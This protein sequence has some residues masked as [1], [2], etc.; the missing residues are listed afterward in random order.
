MARVPR[1]KFGLTD[2]QQ[3]RHDKLVNYVMETGAIL[4]PMSSITLDLDDYLN[5][6]NLKVKIDNSLELIK[7][8]Q[9][10]FDDTNLYDYE[11]NLNE[12]SISTIEAKELD[13]Y[14]IYLKNHAGD[15]SSIFYEIKKHADKIKEKKENEEKLKRFDEKR[16]EIL[17]D[18]LALEKEFESMKFNVRSG[19]IY[20][21]TKDIILEDRHE[22]KHNLGPF[23]ISYKVKDAYLKV[24]AIA[25][26]PNLHQRT[27][28][29]HPHIEKNGKI[30]LGD[31][32]PTLNN[33][34][35]KSDIY[36]IFIILRNVLSNYNVASPYSQLE[37]WNG[38]PCNHCGKSTKEIELKHCSFCNDLICEE[39]YK[40]FETGYS[41][42]KI[43]ST[44]QTET[45]YICSSVGC[46]N[47]VNP[48]FSEKCNLCNRTDIPENERNNSEFENSISQ[49]ESE[50]VDTTYEVSLP[51]F[52]LI[53]R[54]LLQL[55]ETPRENLNPERELINWELQTSENS[56]IQEIIQAAEEVFYSQ[57]RISSEFLEPNSETSIHIEEEQETVT[58]TCSNCGNDAGNIICH[59]CQQPICNACAGASRCEDC[60]EVICANCR[61]PCSN[62]RI[63]V[64]LAC[65]SRDTEGNI[66]CSGCN[67]IEEL[68]TA[69]PH[70]STIEH[71]EESDVLSNEQ[72]DEYTSPF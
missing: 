57:T 61:I 60:G 65:T 71:L 31:S 38:I 35:K 29:F 4:N 11:D 54:E 48:N 12:Y 68:E 2:N 51:S 41:K 17:K 13:K 52:N 20:V 10:F 3:K 6:T 58:L 19:T 5:T 45:K 40:E 56:E 63:P 36:S 55:N 64:H 25:I 34:H 44:C 49:E 32:I 23:R 22:N 59:D 18:I 66:I 69:S 43:C 30:C 1:N 16:E 27:E 46:D 14:G 62:C 47:F 67:P 37:T 39:C 8:I 70:E 53:N 50:E 15:L 42:Y 24:K 26:N 33:A 7:Q 72:S 21:D 28:Y 9:N